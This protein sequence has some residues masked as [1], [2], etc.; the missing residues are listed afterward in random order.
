MALGPGAARHAAERRLKAAENRI[1]EAIGKSDGRRVT[2]D[3]KLL[4]ISRFDWE[5]G[6]RAKY[7]AAGWKVA[8]WQ[9]E[10]RDGDFI[11]LQA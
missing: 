7:V 10:L 2:V 9:S 11:D 5:D 1:D 4:G 8:H 3:V 6:L